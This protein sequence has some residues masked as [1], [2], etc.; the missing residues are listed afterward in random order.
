D[1][2]AHDG[3][4][5]SGWVELRA[6]LWPADGSPDQAADHGAHDADDRRGDDAHGVDAGQDG[7]GDEAHD[8]THDEGPKDVEHG[9]LLSPP[10]L[11]LRAS[12][13]G[14]AG[15]MT[16]GSLARITFSRGCRSRRWAGTGCRRSP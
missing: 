4:D 3:H 13:P 8:E 7:A 15:L 5:E 6:R 9:D 14:P 2:R 12:L 10:A 1:K 16:W 11:S